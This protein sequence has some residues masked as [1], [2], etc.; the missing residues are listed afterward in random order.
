METAKPGIKQRGDDCLELLRALPKEELIR[1]IA[2]DAKNW[3][4]HDGLWFQAVESLAG[5]ETAIQADTLA[6]EK[7]T[8]IEAK[9]IMGRL[10]MAPGGGLKALGECLKHRFYARLNTQ[11][12]ELLNE[13]KAVFHMLDCRVQT[14]RKKKGLPD[15]PCRSVGIV[16]YSGFASAVDPRIGTRCLACPPDKHPAEYWCGWEFT[17]A[18]Q[19][20]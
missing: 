2:D 7:F 18:N 16:E 9:R 19:D 11:K 13:K 17:I 5:M 8:V 10:G 3:L 12:F 1:I 15:F 20:E 6:W 4:A 14:A